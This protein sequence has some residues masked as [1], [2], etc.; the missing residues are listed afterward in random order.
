ML[1]ATISYQCRRSQGLVQE[2]V[3]GS[4]QLAVHRTALSTPVFFDPHRAAIPP[5]LL[6]VEWDV[7]LY[8]LNS[9]H[10][11]PVCLAVS[12]GDV[13]SLGKRLV[14]PAAGHSR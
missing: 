10:V 9:P 1:T 7:K 3:W 14:Y 4:P 5:T 8:S 6:Y 12:N 11:P 2:N 13:H